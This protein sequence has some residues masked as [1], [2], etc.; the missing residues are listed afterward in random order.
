MY[1]KVSSAV[2]PTHYPQTVIKKESKLL[3]IVPEALDTKQLDEDSEIDINES[4][5]IMD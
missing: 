5:P 4:N 1:K 3:P 2:K